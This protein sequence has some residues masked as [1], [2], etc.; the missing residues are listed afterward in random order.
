MPKEVKQ[1]D[2]P[3][4]QSEDSDEM[5]R[6]EDYDEMRV[7]YQKDLEEAQDDHA[8]Q[9]DDPVEETLEQAST[10]RGPTSADLEVAARRGI[11]LP[12]EHV[13]RWVS[14]QST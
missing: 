13:R 14:Y 8:D 5:V 12:G 6:P 9:F 1:E 7:K 3:T 2:P 4:P 11:H 10:P